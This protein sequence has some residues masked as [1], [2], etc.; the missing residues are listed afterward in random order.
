[1][2]YS[3]IS[4]YPK[5]GVDPF[6]TGQRMQGNALDYQARQEGKSY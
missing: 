5:K 3:S 6:G 1:L 4:G 2:T